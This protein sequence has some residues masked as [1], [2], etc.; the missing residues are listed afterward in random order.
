MNLNLEI[1][2]QRELT[3]VDWLWISG[4]LMFLALMCFRIVFLGKGANHLAVTQ[5]QAILRT[6][7]PT[8]VTQP[9][10]ESNPEARASEVLSQPA[11]PAQSR[12]ATDELVTPDPKSEKAVRANT[13]NLAVR[14]LASRRMVAIDKLVRKN[15]R[16]LIAM[17]RRIF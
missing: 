12:S 1:E 8:A 5:A 4:A 10:T 16:M 9:R 11:Q 3:L 6:S 17:W 2:R 15:V 14:R 13:R 7:T